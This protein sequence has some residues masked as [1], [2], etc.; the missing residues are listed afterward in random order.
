MRSGSAWPTTFSVDVDTASYANVRRFL[1]GGTRPPKD[2]VRIEELVNYFAYDY[3]DPSGSHPFSVTTEIG[4]CPWAPEHRLV[5]VGLQGR[6]IEAGKM[7]ARN[8]V[9]LV[10]VSGS[11]GA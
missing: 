9:F 2:A 1:N 8:L 3:P 10:D 5:L 7:P 6:R 11:R 4:P